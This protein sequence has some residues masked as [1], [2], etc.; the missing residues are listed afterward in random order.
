MALSVPNNPTQRPGQP[1]RVKRWH[2]TANS[3][4]CKWHR[5]DSKCHTRSFI[6]TI[7]PAATKS[8]RSLTT[9]D[10]VVR[11]PAFR[12]SPGDKTANRI[13]AGSSRHA[14]LM[15]AIAEKAPEAHGDCSTSARRNTTAYHRISRSPSHDHPTQR[16]LP[17][18]QEFC[19]GTGPMTLTSIGQR[20]YH[21]R[22]QRSWR[23]ILRGTAAE[24]KKASCGVTRGDFPRD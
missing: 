20:Y 9:G 24:Q 19:G 1:V 6:S 22:S 10:A 15:N 13:G 4:A 21:R 12:K 5:H 8:K 23:A 7:Q 18:D 2:Q 14:V 11:H 16:D 3:R 17:T